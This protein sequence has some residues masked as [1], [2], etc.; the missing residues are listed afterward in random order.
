MAGALVRLNVGVV[1]KRFAIFDARERIADVCLACA[2]RFDLAA[3]Q[4]DARFVA[5]ET[6]K[7]RSALRLRIVSAAMIA[8]AH[9][10]RN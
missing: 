8:L 7:S 1:K 2:D 9:A 3:F 5:I 6:V 4:L 10:P